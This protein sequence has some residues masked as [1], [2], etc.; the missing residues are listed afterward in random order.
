MRTILQEYA[1]SKSHPFVS[2]F[3]SVQIA[4]FQNPSADRVFDILQTFNREWADGLR[5]KSEG[6]I[7]DHVNSIVSN[8]HNIAHG[9]LSGISFVTIASYYESAQ[10][11][12]QLLQE[13]CTD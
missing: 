5:A 8:R 12:V 9:A 3:V 4:R 13:Q 2:N 10:R 7:T 1:R 11:F 6:K